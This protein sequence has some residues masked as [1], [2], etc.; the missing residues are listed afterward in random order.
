MLPLLLIGQH[1]LD[2]GHGHHGYVA[3]EQK[4]QHEE[5]SEAPDQGEG[6]HNA[7]DQR[8]ERGQEHHDHDQLHQRVAAGHRVA[9]PGAQHPCPKS[10]AC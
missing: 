8:Q 6:Q 5:Q 3:Y 9:D 7:R 2:L 1:R 4:E 10:A